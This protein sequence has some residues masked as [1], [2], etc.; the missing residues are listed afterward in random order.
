[1]IQLLIMETD[2]RTNEQAKIEKSLH[3]W[4]PLGPA[5]KQELQIQNT[6][7]RGGSKNTWE[8]K[9]AKISNKE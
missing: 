6:Q 3:G 2:E 4:P 8:Q 7:Q 1:M 9:G 5:K